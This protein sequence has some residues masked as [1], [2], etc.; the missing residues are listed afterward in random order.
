MELILSM[1]IK[2][3]KVVVSYVEYGNIYKTEE[4][5]NTKFMIELWKKYKVDKYFNIREDYEIALEDKKEESDEDFLIKNLKY[6]R[7]DFVN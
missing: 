7:M 1:V 5:Q 6:L 3:D 4:I 2:N